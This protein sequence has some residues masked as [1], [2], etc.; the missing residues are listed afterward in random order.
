MENRTITVTGLGRESIAPDQIV[1]NIT[2]EAKDGDYS[3]V[4]ALQSEQARE[5]KAAAEQMGFEKGC[6]K[7]ASFS[8][9]TEY[10]N[11]QTEKG[12]W[13]RQFKGYCCRHTLTLKFDSDKD[14]LNNAVKA[15]TSCKKSAPTF[16]IQFTVK[17]KEQFTDSLLQKAVKDACHKAEVIASA[18]GMKLGS[19]IS[20]SYLSES[21]S[22]VS[23]AVAQFKLYRSASVNDAAG[24][25]IEA[26]NIEGKA[27]I[28]AV[29]ELL[30]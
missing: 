14:M 25:E 3:A 24:V 9:D 6:L 19:L 5:L 21:A 16:N 26:E 1:I 4:N 30:A 11:Y 27:E 23:P 8:I 28:E 17:D 20:I 29:W 15:I 7:T 13:V 22:I 18:S 10:E 12:N 2:L